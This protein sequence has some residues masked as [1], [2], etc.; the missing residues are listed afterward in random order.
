MR[1]CKATQNNTAKHNQPGSL[2]AVHVHRHTAVFGVFWWDGWQ[3]GCP[4][5]TGLLA[6]VDVKQQFHS[7]L[8]DWLVGW[9]LQVLGKSVKPIP[10]MVLGVLVAGKRYPIAKYLFVLMIVMG[11]ALFMYKDQKSSLKEAEHTVG[12]GEVLLVSWW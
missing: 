6:S 8:V 5:Q 2:V 10:V 4:S 1:K 3:A 9:L 7:W 11:V 12:I